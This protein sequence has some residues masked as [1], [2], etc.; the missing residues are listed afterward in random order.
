[1][2]AQILS[3]TRS[4]QAKKP[5]A[6]LVSCTEFI[7]CPPSAFFGR[8]GRYLLTGLVPCSGIRSKPPR[9]TTIFETFD[10]GSA[11]SPKWRALVG[12]VRTQDGTDRK[13]T[14][15]NSSH[16]KISY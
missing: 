6:P 1:M 15:L 9:S 5:E 12:Q 8:G 13:S 10:A 4:T 14:R 11:K 7:P 2:N 16:V 3:S